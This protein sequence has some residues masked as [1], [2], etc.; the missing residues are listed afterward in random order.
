[1][2]VAVTANHL[3]AGGVGIALA[4]RI[5]PDWLRWLLA[6]VFLVM[7]VS[8]LVPD[9]RA[10]A[11]RSAAPRLEGG[12]ERLA[13]SAFPA[14]LVTFFLAEMG[15]KTQIATLALAARFH[16]LALVMIGSTIGMMAA[17]VPVIWFG[18]RVTR[19]L[20]AR[21]L[22]RASAALFAAFGLAI[23]AGW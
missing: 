22:R 23:L 19:R 9:L 8:L 18:E 6:A 15:D 7:A 2:L 20:P 14:A 21:L 17:D 1:M 12:G 5:S 10:G 3:L 16:S 4:D 13:G 11:A